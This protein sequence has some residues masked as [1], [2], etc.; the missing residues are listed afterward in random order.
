MSSWR[1][2]L[3]CP[4]GQHPLQEYENSLVCNTCSQTYPQVN[5]VTRFLEKDRQEKMLDTTD[6]V[7]MVQA[8]RKPNQNLQKLRRV[9]TSEYFPGKEWQ[10]ARTQALEAEGARLI[11]GSGV[12]KYEDA[13]HLDIDD[14]SGVDVVADAHHLPF[15]DESMGAVVCETVLEHVARPDRIIAEAARVTRPGGRFFFIVPFLFPFHGQP[16]DYQRWTREGLLAS[17]DAFSH[18]E[19][20]IHGGPCSAFVNVLTEWL[21]VCSGLTFPKGYTVIKGG[22]TALF[23]P[24]KF[25]DR[26]VNRFP[27]AHRLAATLYVAGTK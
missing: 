12:S 16:G 7:S 11:I 23:F 8:Y 21:Y 2:W 13:I 18:V 14:F 10:L 4:V 15:A 27:E 22:S 25:L 6:G 17:F 19:V 20:G 3:R 1:E 26:I 24:I 5:G 9:I